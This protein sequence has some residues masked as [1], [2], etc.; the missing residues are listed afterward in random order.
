MRIPK[1]ISSRNFYSTIP[2]MIS[3]ILMYQVDS[4]SLYLVPL[5]IAALWW[6]FFGVL[7]FVGASFILLYHRVGGLIGISAV[8]LV[9]LGVV[10]SRLDR[11][12]AP[13]SDYA[14]VTA[15]ILLSIPTYYLLL[16]LSSLLSGFE[17]TLLAVALFASLYFFIK[18]VSGD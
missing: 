4:R 15:A 2:L 13:P 10:T 12:R 9:F 5:L 8:A 14:A 18:A 3:F 17:A 6:Y 7:Y 1:S 16:P 11:E